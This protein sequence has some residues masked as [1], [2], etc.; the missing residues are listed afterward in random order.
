MFQT[1][2][3]SQDVM[4]AEAAAFI[5]NAVNCQE[6]PSGH[7]GQVHIIC[8]GLRKACHPAMVE[9]RCLLWLHPE[10]LEVRL[11]MALQWCSGLLGL[12]EGIVLASH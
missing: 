8:D 11:P 12:L 6:V 3:D 4:T 9:R 2:E 10:L 1:N 7:M 5:A